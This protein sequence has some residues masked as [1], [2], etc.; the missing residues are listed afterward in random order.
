MGYMLISHL[1]VSWDHQKSSK[2]ASNIVSHLDQKLRNPI[3]NSWTYGHHYEGLLAPGLKGLF[4]QLKLVQPLGKTW[5][6]PFFLVQLYAWEIRGVVLRWAKMGYS[7]IKELEYASM[8]RTFCAGLFNS[9]FKE[10]IPDVPLRKPAA[11]FNPILVQI[12]FTISKQLA[13]QLLYFIT[14]TKC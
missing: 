2:E 13:L 9:D 4:E 1:K 3:I 8:P 14:L 11:C 10:I 12:G 6:V 7:G 5:S